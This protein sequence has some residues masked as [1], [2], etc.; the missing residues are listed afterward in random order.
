MEHKLAAFRFMINRLNNLPLTPE[1]RQQEESVIRHVATSNV[2]PVK[3]IQLK[4]NIAIKDDHITQNNQQTQKW[5]TF[6]FHSPLIGKI[7]N[8]FKNT[9]IR[10]AFQAT[11]T[12]WQTLNVKKSTNIHSNGGVYSLKCSRTPSL[13]THQQ[14]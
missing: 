10:I 2:Y 5:V 13:C 12:L 9:N 4:Q 3:L 8:I 7:T 1:T 11:D 6:K 14:S